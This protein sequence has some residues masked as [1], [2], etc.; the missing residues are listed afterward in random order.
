MNDLS[1]N[2]I[3]HLFLF[4]K[5]HY[6]RSFD[7][8]H[9]L[10]PMLCDVLTIIHRAYGINDPTPEDA[11]KLMLPW[12]WDSLSGAVDFQEMIMFFRNLILH[13]NE[14]EEVT[15]IGADEAICQMMLVIMAIR[16]TKDELELGMP[17]TNIMVCNNN[18]KDYPR[19]YKQE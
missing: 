8:K 5:G 15:L 16:I 2:P 7:F 11:F 13:V 3:R 10:E 19:K 17:D 1:G 9:G 12:V 4:A 6:Q 14:N 18:R